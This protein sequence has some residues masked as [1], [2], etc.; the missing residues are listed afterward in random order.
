MRV[1]YQPVQETPGDW[2]ECGSEEW[3][4]LESCDVNAINV[5]G[6]V[7]EGADHY[8]VRPVSPG[9]V[10]VIGW[11]DDPA[12]WPAGYRWARV[13]VV[14]HLTPDPSKNGAINTWQ[15]QV[16]YAETEIE[17]VLAAAYA[18]NPMIEI[19]PWSYFDPGCPNPMPGIWLSDQQY[20][21]H[22]SAR[23]VHGWREWTEGLDPSELDENGLVKIQRTLGRYAPAEGTRTYYHLLTDLATGCHVALNEN[24]LG[25]ATGTVDTETA[26][27]DHNGEVAWAATTPAGEPNSA[28]WPTTGVYRAQLDVAS[29]GADLSFGLLTRN[30]SVGH[31]G[32]TDSGLTS[33][34]QSFEQSQAAFTGPG[35][36]LATVTD[37]AWTSGAASDRFEVLVAGNRDVGH[38]AQDLV[39]QLGEADDYADGPWEAAAGRRI[40]IT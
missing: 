20:A 34:L 18:G 28:A 21:D 11:H 15:T 14:R 35:L 22:Q 12:D 17:K 37:P 39:L 4:G 2:R 27:I 38:G 8:S 13:I 19:K 30:G 10:D 3:A 9:V 24:E 32:R 40:F 36:H 16:I 33:C 25:T 1:L 26:S 23:E 29:A 5:Q 6:V 7:F 31:F